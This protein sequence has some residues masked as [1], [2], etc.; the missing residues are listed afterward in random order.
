MRSNGSLRAQRAWCALAGLL[1][2]QCAAA[3]EEFVVTAT[4][5]F[6]GDSFIALRSDGA[7]V[8]VRLGGI[9]AP[10]KGQ[11]YANKARTALR[12]LILGEELR[13]EVTDTDKY[14]RKIAQVYRVSDGMHVN[15]ELLRRGCAWVYRRVPPDHPFHEFERTARAAELGLWALP[16]SER[17]PPWRWRQEHPSTR[18][19]P[20]PP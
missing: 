1:L 14:H 2:L 3:R 5:V 4:H 9:D 18:T 16:E 15:A 8:E 13:V 19:T 11:P 20:A 12:S 10:E 6:D 7:D 17:E